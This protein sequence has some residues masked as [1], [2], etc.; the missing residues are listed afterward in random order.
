MLATSIVPVGGFV[1]LEVVAIIMLVLCVAVVTVNI[2]HL[3]LNLIS[4]S[5]NV[6]GFDLRHLC[7]GNFF[8]TSFAS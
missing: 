7:S 2:T 5:R 4:F 1:V 8:V 6:F 3:V